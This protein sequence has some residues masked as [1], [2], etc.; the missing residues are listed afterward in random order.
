MFERTI[1]AIP[2]TCETLPS[3]CLISCVDVA[4]SRT[5]EQGFSVSVKSAMSGRLYTTLVPTIDEAWNFI[6]TLL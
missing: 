3:W 2:D 6:Y 5:W 1:Y 4:I